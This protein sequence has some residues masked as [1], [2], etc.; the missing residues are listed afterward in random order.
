MSIGNILLLSQVTI[1]VITFLFS[2]FIV[3]PL[4]VYEAQF[5]GHCL[6]FATGD[7]N[8][9]SLPVEQLTV[10]WGDGGYCKYPIVMGILALPL[11]LFYILWMSLHLFKD[12]DLSWLASFVALVT[13][14]TASFLML[15]A[16]IILTT[17]FK[18]WC[19]F[20]RR[21]I[22]SSCDVGEIVQ[23][24]IGEDID[25]S[26]YYVEFG[27]AQFGTWLSWICWVI[28][29]GLASIKLWR[30]HRQENFFISMKRERTRLIQRMGNNNEVL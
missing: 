22:A 13:S 19:D 3:I 6:L 18:K 9:S 1:Y 30:F 14:V 24:S 15:V 27:M 28:Q 25:K 10:Q 21:S 26:G 7:L 17:G 12:Y 2:L 5:N 8:V 16:G 29:T 23:F 4:T 11:S 20:L